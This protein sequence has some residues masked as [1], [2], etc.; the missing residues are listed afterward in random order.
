MMIIKSVDK[1]FT[2]E[3]MSQFRA[4]YTKYFDESNYANGENVPT[5][6]AR[7][8]TKSARYASEMIKRIKV[9]VRRAYVSFGEGH[10][11]N[12]FI[13]GAIDMDGASISH[14]YAS[15]VSFIDKR[16]IELELTKTFAE[17]ALRRG[18]H[19]MQARCGVNEEDLIDSLKI[20][21]FDYS[22]MVGKEA[23]YTRSTKM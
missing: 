21:G 16:R 10:E 4:A 13:V 20:L 2:E 15:G 18:I 9:G 11:L 14:L 7:L 1:D 17:A 19:S 12:G 23:E 8:N 3:E 6:L 5:I 22:K